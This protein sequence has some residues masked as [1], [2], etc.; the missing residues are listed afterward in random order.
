M[1]S[2]FLFVVVGTPGS[3]KDILIQA[4]NDMGVLHAQTV[5]KHVNRNRQDDDGEEM[6]CLDDKKF[7]LESCD[8]VYDNY[9]K[10]YGFEVAPIWK[11]LRKGVHQVLVVSNISAMNEIRNRFGSLSKF[12]FVNSDMDPVAYR[13]EQEALGNDPEYIEN[14]VRGYHGALSSYFENINLFDHVLIYSDSQEDLFDQIF[15]LFD[16]YD[17]K[18]G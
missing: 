10:T 1:N 6:I 13:E 16:F 15:R 8:I 5:P 18:G 9:G 2:A 11:G 7:D 14:R 3:G 4:V 17:R 12:V